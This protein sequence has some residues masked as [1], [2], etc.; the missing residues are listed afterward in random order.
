MLQGYF[1]QVWHSGAALWLQ[2]LGFSAV[3]LLWATLALSSWNQL[4]A[5][6]Q[7]Q[8]GSSGTES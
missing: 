4:W 2:Q 3:A 5:W 6:K 8:M 7:W 1:P